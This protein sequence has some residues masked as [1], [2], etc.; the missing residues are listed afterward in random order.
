MTTRKTLLHAAMIRAMDPP[1]WKTEKKIRERVFE[2]FGFSDKPFMP[3]APSEHEIREV[4]D[5]WL[6]SGHMFER[7]RKDYLPVFISWAHNLEH[8]KNLHP[9]WRSVVMQQRAKRR[10]AVEDFFR[11]QRK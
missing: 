3:D 6:K 8:V 1:T 4:M 9:G 11:E 5:D 7:E 10:A 2:L